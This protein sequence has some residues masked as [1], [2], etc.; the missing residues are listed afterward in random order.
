MDITIIGTGNMA[1]GIASRALA[2]GN[3]VTLLGH[4]GAAEAESLAGDLRS[5]AAA[6]V[7]T[8]GVGDPIATETV[9]LA[10]PY[11]AA[12]DVVAHYGDQLS[13]KVVVDITNPLN[14]TYDGLVSTPAGSAAQEI[15]AAA[16]GARVV[17]AFN[18]TFA[19]PLVSG[20]VAGQPLDVLIAGDD[21]AAKETVQELARGGGLRPIDAGPLARSRELEAIGFEHISLQGSL[22]TGFASSIK[23]LA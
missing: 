4:H 7:T 15:A 17:K 9:V 8:G 10:V 1:R 22:G 13:G 14:A 23:I 20:E 12:G 6:A 2:G 11:A 18:T 3:G 5:G 16:P 21:G 19:G